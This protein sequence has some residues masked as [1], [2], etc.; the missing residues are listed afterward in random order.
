MKAVREPVLSIGNFRALLWVP[1]L[2]RVQEAPG[3][4]GGGGAMG[5]SRAVP[6]R[7]Q[8]PGPAGMAVVPW[9]GGAAVP[10]CHEHPAC[11][12][13]AGRKRL[14]RSWGGWGCVSRCVS[15]CVAL[16]PRLLT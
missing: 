14:C 7:R 13:V 10:W 12:G 9:C 3:G 2:S 15:R 5:R 6:P 8:G 4:A 1:S 16:V 11:L